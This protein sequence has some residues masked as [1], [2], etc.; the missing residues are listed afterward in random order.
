M[1]SVI[2]DDSAVKR[3]NQLRAQ[4]DKPALRLRITVDSGGCSGFQYILA[5]DEETGA[6]DHV[7][8][9]AVV[10]DA[11]SLPFLQGARISFGRDLV[12][13][14]FKIDNPN[15][16]SGCGCGSSFSIG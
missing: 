5:L 10:C 13:S 16:V 12:G 1:D 3:I 4:Q 7:F 8:A 6:D 15:A 2:I 11:V 9:D 14:Q